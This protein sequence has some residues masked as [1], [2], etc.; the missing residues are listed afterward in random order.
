MQ[1][2]TSKDLLGRESFLEKSHIDKYASHWQMRDITND[3][4]RKLYLACKRRSGFPGNMPVTVD[5]NENDISVHAILQGLGLVKA[6]PEDVFSQDS[7]DPVQNI[8]RPVREA[9]HRGQ[10]SPS[11]S[12][13]VSSRS[14]SSSSYTDT[15]LISPHHVNTTLPDT[16]RLSFTNPSQAPY[17]LEGVESSFAHEWGLQLMTDPLAPWPHP[18][19]T[20]PA[21]CDA[22]LI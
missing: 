14:R 18:L 19:P 3:A 17:N 1:T 21:F 9:Q 11:T 20:E 2:R 16:N 15:S 12:A 5:S 6:S 7:K 10:Y 4:L 22:L 8:E 13:S